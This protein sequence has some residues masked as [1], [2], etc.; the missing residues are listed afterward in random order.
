MKIG[1]YRLGLALALLSLLV[2][3]VYYILFVRTVSVTKL[4]TKN[5]TKPPQ[6]YIKWVEDKGN[7]LIE[8]KQIDNFMFTL[9]YIPKDYMMLKE[10][11]ALS[12]SKLHEKSKELGDL[13]Y[14][15]FT[16]S[17]VDEKDVMESGIVSQE[18]YQKRIEYFSFQMQNDLKLIDGNDTLEC[19]LFNFERTFGIQ[20]QCRFNLAFESVRK[21]G[22][23]KTMVFNDQVLGLGTVKLSLLTKN[24]ENIP[25]LKII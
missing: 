6:K 12:D 4:L 21:S 2:F 15:T 1:K 10:D 5:E 8:K 18:E 13:Q 16:I 23:Y 20:P 9:Q 22:E 11:P 19:V 7:G 17:S 3:G 14:F 25:H 24:L